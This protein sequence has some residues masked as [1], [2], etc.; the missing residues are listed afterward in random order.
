[1]N[2]LLRLTLF[3]TLLIGCVSC[4]SDDDDN[5]SDNTPQQQQSGPFEPEEFDTRIDPELAVTGSKCSNGV[6]STP[7]EIPSNICEDDEWLVQLDDQNTCSADLSTCTE[8][9]VLPTVAKLQLQPNIS[10]N[11]F[12]YYRVAA[13]NPVSPG[14]QR[15][16]NRIWIRTAPN[17]D[18][19]AVLR[20]TVR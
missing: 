5:D 4:G 11:E 9:Y 17:G 1:M 14:Q 15:V 19:E 6:G 18:T 10:N 16:I 8:I 7:L 3:L 12:T 2:K 13:E 20:N